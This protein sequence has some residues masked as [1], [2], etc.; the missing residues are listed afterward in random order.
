MLRAARLERLT[1]RATRVLDAHGCREELMRASA[2]EPNRELR[3]EE[4]AAKGWMQLQR[5]EPVL[6]LKVPIVEVTVGDR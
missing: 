4:E 2:E 6:I 5:I 3:V 1:E